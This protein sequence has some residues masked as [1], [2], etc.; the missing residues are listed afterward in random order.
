[1]LRNLKR[2]YELIA[3]HEYEKSW[4]VLQTCIDNALLVMRFSEEHEALETPFILA[5]LRSYERLYPYTYFM[6]IECTARAVCSICRKPLDD[7]A[8]K[9][10]VGRMY[11][12]EVAYARYEDIRS[13][14]AV[15]IVTNPKDK[16]C[17]LR[18]ADDDLTEVEAHKDLHTFFTEVEPLRM[19]SIVKKYEND[20]SHPSDSLP[21][22]YSFHV[23][24]G[25][26]IAKLAA[27]A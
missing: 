8:C 22:R 12:G 14:P 2:Y 10:L 23:H 25:P 4:D 21:R 27:P 5:M 7:P 6:S 26:K 15:A 16:R 11:W 24:I 13:A 19:V 1:M 17:V 18:L 3:L 9:H 20:E